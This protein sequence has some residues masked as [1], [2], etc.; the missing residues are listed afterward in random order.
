[1]REKA[2]KIVAHRLEAAP[3]DIEVAEGKYRVRGSPDKAMTLA[4]A[5]R[6]HA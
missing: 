1:M 5:E 4:E 2:K 6:W 3:E